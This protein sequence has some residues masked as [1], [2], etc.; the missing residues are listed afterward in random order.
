M[1][2]RLALWFYNYKTDRPTCPRAAVTVML[3]TLSRLATRKYAHVSVNAG[4]WVFSY[5]TRGYEVTHV[6]HAPKPDLIIEMDAVNPRRLLE[7]DPPTKPKLLWLTIPLSLLWPK[8][9]RNCATL[10]GQLVGIKARTPDALYK[11]ASEGSKP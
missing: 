10:S 4:A 7:W 3:Q 5:S 1:T 11:A 9:F 2:K 8:R 6:E